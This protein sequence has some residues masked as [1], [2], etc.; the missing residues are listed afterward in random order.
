MILIT[1]IVGALL[2]SRQPRHPAGW[3]WLLIAIAVSVDQL[4]FGYVNYGMNADVGS[5][6]AVNLALLWQSNNALPVGVIGFT[7]LML[8]FPDGKLPTPLWRLVVVVAIVAIVIYML[9][10][11][12][13][14]GSLMTMPNLDNPRGA[15]EAVWRLLGPI[16]WSALFVALLALLAAIASLFVRLRRTRGADRQYIK[17]LVYVMALF[18]LG[19]FVQQGGY[20]LGISSAETLFPVGFAL[21]IIAFTGLTTTVVIAIFKVHLYDIDIII[22]RTLVYGLLTVLLA[23]I[24]FS[25]VILLQLLLQVLTRQ[26]SPLALVVSTLLI[27]ALFNPL[28]CRV[29]DF[30]DRRFYRQKY[31]AAKT[32]AQFA[33]STRVKVDL[34]EL[35]AGLVRVVDETMQPEQVTLWLKSAAGER[36]DSQRN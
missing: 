36:G 17:W 5:L 9:L 12:I 20:A 31:D 14:P 34:N 13:R 7:I 15:G 11:M 32:S 2:I 22:N 16:M 8:T 1:A 35:T 23:A 33:A 21:Q 19:V 24:Y 27:A 3:T 6:P 30:I 10:A 4:S 28:R 26:E 18:V 29:Q 25:S